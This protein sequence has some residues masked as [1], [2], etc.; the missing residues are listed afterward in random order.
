MR[1]TSRRFSSPSL[2]IAAREQGREI[3]RI[4][5]Y[6]RRN[7]LHDRPHAYIEDVFVD[8]AFRGRGALRALHERAIA[9]A[10]RRGCYKIVLTSRNGK[11]DV[12]AMYRHLGYAKH[13]LEFRLDIE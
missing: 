11:P 7:D 4:Y 2:R 12:H 5:L 1:I 8:G 10:R 13:G 9:E 3:G 6:I